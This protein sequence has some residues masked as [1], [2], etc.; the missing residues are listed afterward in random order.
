MFSSLDD[1]GL[2][3]QPTPLNR[4]KLSPKSLEITQ[5]I[6][7]ITDKVHISEQPQA[8]NRLFSAELLTFEQSMDIAH[9]LANEGQ[10]IFPFIAK[11]FPEKIQTYL[12]QNYKHLS[13]KQ[14]SEIIK[15]FTL[16][17]KTE[18]FNLFFK[19]NLNLDSILSILK[20]IKDPQLYEQVLTIL[21]PG[22][23]LSLISKRLY[24]FLI[25]ESL[26]EHELLFH[27]LDILKKSPALVMLA[28][29]EKIPKR[30]RPFPIAPHFSLAL[31]TFQ[32]NLMAISWLGYVMIHFPDLTSQ[33]FEKLV[34][35]VTQLLETDDFGENFKWELTTLLV[36]HIDLV[37]KLVEK[38]SPDLVIAY[39]N[40]TD[41]PSID[42]IES[43]LWLTTK[44]DDLT[45]VLE[46]LFHKFEEEDLDIS[47][48]LDVILPKLKPDQKFKIAKVLANKYPVAFSQN[49]HLFNFKGEQLDHVSLLALRAHKKIH[50]GEIIKQD[51]SFGLRLEEL[52]NEEK[53]SILYLLNLDEKYRFIIDEKLRDKF[54]T[55][56]SHIKRI[57]Q[58]SEKRTRVLAYKYLYLEDLFVPLLNLRENDLGNILR[59]LDSFPP[60]HAKEAFSWLHQVH[61]ET[62]HL[63]DCAD[64]LRGACLM[65]TEYFDRYKEMP[66]LIRNIPTIGQINLIRTKPEL[67]RFLDS[68][69]E[70]A[71][72]ITLAIGNSDLLATFKRTYEDWISHLTEGGAELDTAV[73]LID[74]NIEI[75]IHALRTAGGERDYA[76]DTI[77]QDLFVQCI[78][79]FNYPIDFARKG[80]HLHS[81][82]EWLVQDDA[83]MELPYFYLNPNLMIIGQNEKYEENLLDSIRRAPLPFPDLTQLN[84][85]YPDLMRLVLDWVPS[86]EN[87]YFRDALDIAFFNEDLFADLMT[88]AMQDITLTTLKRLNHI[89]ACYGAHN[90]R[91][92]LQVLKG[93]KA[94][95]LDLDKLFIWKDHKRFDTKVISLGENLY[96]FDPATLEY[97]LRN[98]DNPS[99]IDK[100]IGI[101]KKD[102]AQLQKI[103]EMERAGIPIW[104]KHFDVN[105][106]DAI[107]LARRSPGFLEAVEELNWQEIPN[108]IWQSNPELPLKLT[109]LRKKYGSA[110]SLNPL[111]HEVLKVDKRAAAYQLLELDE[112]GLLTKPLL[113]SILQSPY[114]RYFASLFNAAPPEPVPFSREVEEFITMVLR[115]SGETSLHQLSIG[116]KQMLIPIINQVMNNHKLMSAFTAHGQWSQILLKMNIF[117]LSPDVLA[118]LLENISTGPP[119]SYIIDSDYQRGIFKEIL[120]KLPKQLVE[121][122]LKKPEIMLV[123]LCGKLYPICQS[124]TKEEMAILSNTPIDLINTVLWTPPGIGHF[125]KILGAHLAN[126]KKINPSLFP[127]LLALPYSLS[128]ETL[129]KFVVSLHG[130]VVQQT[131]LFVQMLDIHPNHPGI[132]KIIVHDRCMK[133]LQKIH[134]PSPKFMAKL[135]SLVT[136]CPLDNIALL[137]EGIG[138]HNVYGEEFLDLAQTDHLKE[139]IQIISSYNAN[140]IPLLKPPNS[141]NAI[142]QIPQW[143]EIFREIAS[144]NPLLTALRPIL[145][146]EYPSEQLRT[147]AIQT[148]ITRELSKLMVPREGVL[149]MPKIDKIDRLLEGL[150]GPDSDV[151]ALLKHQLDLLKTNPNLF[152]IFTTIE[153]N[154]DPKN[155]AY[156]MV[157]D[158]TGQT[159]NKH[160]AQIAALSA[161]LCPLRQEDPISSCFGTGWLIF[162]QSDPVLC[163]LVLINFSI[164]L[165]DGALTKELVGGNHTGEMSFPILQQKKERN[166]FYN[167]LLKALENCLANMSVF[168]KE[169]IISENLALFA[170]SFE[171]PDVGIYADFLNHVKSTTAHKLENDIILNEL[172]K[173]FLEVTKGVFLFT[174]FSGFTLARRDTDEL[175][176]NLNSF[177]KLQKN[178][179]RKAIGNLSK[180]HPSYRPYLGDVML[181]LNAAIDAEPFSPSLF[182]R[183]KIGGYF[184]SVIA[185]DTTY[186][187]SEFP[188]LKL[189]LDNPEETMKYLLNHFDT[190]P[191][192]N[193]AKYIKYS[194]VLL[195]AFFR[196]KGVKEG[197]LFNLKPAPFV[198]SLAEGRKVEEIMADLSKPVQ[199]QMSSLDKPQLRNFL[200][201]NVPDFST[202]T[203]PDFSWDDIQGMTVSE[204]G[205]KFKQ[206]LGI[207]PKNNLMKIEEEFLAFVSAE[208]KKRMNV[209]IIGDLNWQT[210]MGKP[211]YLA[212]GRS[213]LF[214]EPSFYKVTKDK[215]YVLVANDSGKHYFSNMEWMIMQPHY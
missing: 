93:N 179:L 202:T 154:N 62:K 140:P 170:G 2:G 74:V 193:K 185:I 42:V 204:F 215:S 184:T 86:V 91:S 32:D 134:D 147:H 118:H 40:H 20:Q 126:P 208:D 166:E 161:F 112:L 61:F 109:R 92:L 197:H 98:S 83:E 38:G 142:P 153:M 206:K 176:Y 173:A 121:Q 14:M 31:S 26:T 205:M 102:P 84:K 19:N 48:H 63:A 172:R 104:S 189:P 212:Y 106:I 136:Y 160:Q 6:R 23:D 174:E 12:L 99:K 39:I 119:P 214:N 5:K 207:K 171:P 76:E 155:P 138:V 200:N 111:F 196:S 199:M 159:P 11:Q 123:E 168:A 178:I 114:P 144:L 182:S 68:L 192:K 156:Q 87:L 183:P 59:T 108:E 191:E 101:F 127:Q 97:L 181:S 34:S 75:I 95:L 52:S 49:I 139:A 100:A 46:A 157:K 203:I 152:T 143:P 103:I 1:S 51:L 28:A 137:L 175:V 45:K 169:G 201:K 94:L 53:E 165:R 149:E 41:R 132:D 110:K 43:L 66:Q 113:E 54:Y 44:D 55:L 211:Q 13:P 105:F 209:H 116:S 194:E 56:E 9:F 35:F 146:K 47:K 67:Y 17:E 141:L 58:I 21:P 64:Y 18:I 71:A 188:F 150:F 37:P 4:E 133:A 213:L 131:K 73:Q 167:P 81:L 30:G 90:L 128:P 89:Y 50:L 145:D 120:T 130:D 33:Q 88:V 29:P 164:L 60:E 129:K 124:R 115:G 36:N 80:D 8:I 10:N 117:E 151:A 82:A 78:K 24:N 7:N 195:P 190:L 57:R 25:P 148:A 210:S 107:Y 65:L 15:N 27:E 186:K 125:Y 96:L 198:K 3:I 177:Q 135:L 16:K 162:A 72:L 79:I 158:M 77:P 187:E 70:S 85:K 22:E 69:K 180:Q 163:E 122:L